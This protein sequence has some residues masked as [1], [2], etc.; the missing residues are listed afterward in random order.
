[1]STLADYDAVLSYLIHGHNSPSGSATAT[2]P[3]IQTPPLQLTMLPPV[4]EDTLFANPLFKNLYENLT[5]KILNPEDL[6]TRS[7]SRSHH[8]LDQASY[9][10]LQR[11]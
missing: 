8:A 10:L 9:P 6:T 11:T 3:K 7:A 1:M 2:D 5:T 4:L